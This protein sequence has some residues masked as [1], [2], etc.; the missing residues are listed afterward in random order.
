MLLGAK[1]AQYQTELILSVLSSLLGIIAGLFFNLNTAR[2]WS[3]QPV[4]L[5]GIN[6]ISLL[7]GLF[8]FSVDNLYGVILFNVF[9]N[10]IQCVMNASFCFF[11]IQTMSDRL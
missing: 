3:I 1:Y 6:V 8:I 9:I 7:V 4:L 10:A 11:K 2:G 5:I